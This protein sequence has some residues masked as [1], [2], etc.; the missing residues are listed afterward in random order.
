MVFCTSAA[1]QRQTSLA[2]NRT[3]T[4][5][6]Q[7][8]NVTYLGGCYGVEVNLRLILD[9]PIDLTKPPTNGRLLAAFPLRVSELR[10]RTL[11]RRIQKEPYENRAPRQRA[12]GRERASHPACTDVCG[13]R[14]AMSVSITMRNPDDYLVTNANASAGRTDFKKSLILFS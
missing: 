10:Q 1:Q 4:L 3:I 7:L 2:I 14:S 5:D 12:P 9:E 11:R 8:R 6:R 13:G